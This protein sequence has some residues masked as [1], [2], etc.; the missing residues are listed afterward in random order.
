MAMNEDRVLAELTA[1]RGDMTAMRA[2]V[3]GLLSRT[4]ALESRMDRLQTEH[5]KT[6]TDIMA[7]IDRLSDVV[8]ALREDMR[9]TSA[10]TD[11]QRRVHEH[12]REELR[13]Q[14]EI[15]MLLRRQVM[16]LNERVTA[17]EGKV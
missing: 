14:A 10:A 15:V 17:L 5:L 6:R 4:E 3:S 8:T 13:D 7:R 9:V 12:T 11:S 1:I 2:D 16:S